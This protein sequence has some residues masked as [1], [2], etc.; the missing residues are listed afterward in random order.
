MQWKGQRNTEEELT[1][2]LGTIRIDLTRGLPVQVDAHATVGSVRNE[3]PPVAHST[4]TLRLATELGAISVGETQ[5]APGEQVLVS[6]S[7]DRT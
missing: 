4:A 1:T 2:D 7:Q 3:L 5:P 6:T